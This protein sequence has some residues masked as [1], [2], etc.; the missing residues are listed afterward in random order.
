MSKNLLCKHVLTARLLFDK[1]LQ[2]TREALIDLRC[3]A[4]G[5]I[6]TTCFWN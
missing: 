3:Y 2:A 4:G 5:V 6:R 1:I